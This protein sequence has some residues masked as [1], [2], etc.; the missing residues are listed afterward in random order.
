[1][2]SSEIKTDTNSSLIAIVVL[3]CPIVDTYKFY[4]YR[5]LKGFTY[6]QHRFTA[7][8][9]YAFVQHLRRIDHLHLI[10]IMYLWLG[11]SLSLV[12]DNIQSRPG[13][14]LAGYQLVEIELYFLR[15]INYRRFYR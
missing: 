4:A 6:H 8:D 3:H 5:S 12:D 7:S 1:M 14:N 2:A 9:S 15:L 10:G 11:C 13:C